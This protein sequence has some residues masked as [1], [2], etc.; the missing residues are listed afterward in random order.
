[1]NSQ[2]IYR[3][4]M[5]K[6]K[7]ARKAAKLSQDEMAEHIGTTQSTYSKY[8]R[9]AIDITFSQIVKICDKLSLDIQDVLKIKK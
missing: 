6:V 4:F 9:C 1:M 5:N 7:I 3:K 8:E 2:E